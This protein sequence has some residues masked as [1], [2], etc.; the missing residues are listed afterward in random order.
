[1]RKLFRRIRRGS[2]REKNWLKRLVHPN[3]DQPVWP[4]LSNEKLTL[5]QHYTRWLN[6]APRRRILLIC[7]IALY[8]CLGIMWL[9]SVVWIIFGDLLQRFLYP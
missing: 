3:M 2:R 8:V 7:L 1:M 4:F 5:W 9:F 6:A